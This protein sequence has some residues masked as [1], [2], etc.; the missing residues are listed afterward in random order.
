MSPKDSVSCTDTY[1]GR[2]PNVI[3]HCQNPIEGI[4]KPLFGLSVIVVEI[5]W[6]VIFAIM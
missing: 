4:K 2:N 1:D 3:H 6:N 5:S